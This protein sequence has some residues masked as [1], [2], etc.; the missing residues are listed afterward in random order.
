MVTFQT[1]QNKMNVVAYRYRTSLLL[2]VNEN[3]LKLTKYQSLLAK[4]VYLLSYIDIIYKRIFVLDETTV[5]NQIK[6]RQ[7]G[8]FFFV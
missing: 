1:D 2:K 7:E 5:Q 3:Y 8:M 4:R 6:L